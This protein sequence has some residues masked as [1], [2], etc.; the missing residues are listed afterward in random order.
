MRRQITA[1]SASLTLLGLA[2]SANIH[3]ET[4]RW[5]AMPDN[6]YYA[7]DV[8]RNVPLPPASAPQGFARNV[9]TDA[10]GSSGDIYADITNWIVAQNADANPDNDIDFVVQLGDITENGNDLTQWDRAVAAMTRLSDAGVP[11]VTVEGNH[12]C[13]YD[14]D[15]CRD[16]VTDASTDSGY[17][18]LADGKGGTWVADGRDSYHRNYLE[19]FGP[20]T[21]NF[22][23]NLRSQYDAVSP[24]G[25]GTY[26][27]VDL[28][29]LHAVGFIQLPVGNPQ[30]EVDWAKSVIADNPDVK[31]VISTHIANYDAIFTAGRDLEFVT[32]PAIGLVDPIPAYSRSFEEYPLYVDGV[33]VT[34][35]DADEATREA[36][37]IAVGGLA[38]AGCGTG[39]LPSDPQACLDTI[40]SVAPDS[41]NLLMASL[42][43]RENLRY[44]ATGEQA[45][46]GQMLY[47]ELTTQLPNV[48][49]VQ[50]GHTCFETLRTDG[51]NARGVPVVEA[52][53][54]Y[55]CGLNGGEGTVRVYEFDLDTNTFRW[56][57]VI[58]QAGAEN[59]PAIGV[60]RPTGQRRTVMDSFI[61]NI[62]LT[63]AYIYPLLLNQFEPLLEAPV[64]ADGSFAA[65]VGC[66][67]GGLPSDLQAC[68][69]TVQVGN[70][71]A[72]FAIMGE[73]LATQ[74]G[75]QVTV[76]ESPAFGFLT[77]HPDFDEPEEQAYYAAK[78][79]ARFGGDTTQNNVPPGWEN[80]ARFE[81]LWL[82]T[83]SEDEAGQALLQWADPFTFG[84]ATSPAEAGEVIAL[85]SAV[86]LACNDTTT[87][88]AINKFNRCPSG[89]VSVAFDNYSLSRTVVPMLPPILA[90]LTTVAVAGV[91]VRRRQISQN[92]QGSH[93]RQSA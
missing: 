64:V 1:V 65:L 7:K 41:Y 48:L 88:G 70:P 34:P 33:P 22:G 49:M 87:G 46:F 3:A 27:R 73:A 50:S 29:P 68:L 28:D 37:L 81:G 69:D 66:G 21:A 78:L 59:D 44:A 32:A 4:F 58:T 26:V 85:A 43:Y 76:P 53:T 92:G 11:F 84:G 56:E 12:D 45:N 23:G 13:L 52:L 60:A 35:A 17:A 71:S 5:V 36:A 9:I 40:Q 57:T 83:M 47:E 62:F 19:F 61:D 42:N 75:Q 16:I 89:S 20:D 31:F 90:L 67:S 82:L 72:Y 18:E 79:N 6:Q 80:P 93:H 10:R 39:G 24:S 25:L 51:T 77:K 74:I 30:A 54:D 86:V 63:Y 91:A 55:Q 38:T 14:F 15:G 2:V 8:A